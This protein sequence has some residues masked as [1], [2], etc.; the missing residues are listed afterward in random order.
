MGLGLAIDYSLFMVS[1]YREE[2]A[3]GLDYPAALARTMGT[4]GRTVLFSGLAVGTGLAGL[5]FFEGSYLWPMGLGGAIVVALAVIFAM[6]FLPAL[7]AALG[8]RI[9]AGRLPLPQIG[10]GEGPWR[11]L[12]LWVMRRPVLVLVP[13]LALLLAM[14]APFLRLRLSAA[15]VRV[16]TAEV[17]A[18]RGYDLLRRDFPEQAAERAVVA[19][20][21][22]TAPALTE[23]R[24]DALYD[25][26]KRVAAIPHV[27]RVESLV[28]GDPSMSKE[29]CEDTIL[30][31]TGPAKP[32]VEAAKRMTVSDH[33]VLLNAVLDAPPDSDEARGVIRAL[34]ADR[35]V[36]DG[37]LLVGGRVAM[38]TDATAY[39]LERAPRAVGFVVAATFV[40]LFLLLG[41]V[42]LP[43]KAVAMN[44]V[45]IAGSFGALVWLF[46]DGHLFVREA[47]PLEPSLPIL[48]FCVLFG[49]S[50]DYEVLMLSRIKEARDRTGDEVLAVAEGLER[51]AG[52]IT[53]AAAIMVT[54]FAAFALARVIV[55]QAVGVGMALAVLIDA[56]L[57]RVL[58]VPAAMRL[59]GHLNWWAPRP[60]VAL[61]RALGLAHAAPPA[62]E[63][64]IPAP[65]MSAPRPMPA[66]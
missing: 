66:A 56:T 11:R 2:L 64:P 62:P 7:L 23:A 29:D 40:I 1:R 35:R 47:R 32:L 46:Q 3:R 27:R 44:F 55:V 6:T 17:E 15:D 16:L 51:S 33:V 50:M 57:V 5:F 25:L 42:V 65:P 60:L 22:P 59:L 48:L 53:S 34:R 24:V 14:G 39:V 9:H 31:P 45:S 28:G 30:Y 38:D 20:R 10:S 63:P 8:P 43:L 54:V 4:A 21:F 13:S 19:V 49:L 12:A 37:T 36:G 61:R 26:S 58:V 18:R 52:L 41:S